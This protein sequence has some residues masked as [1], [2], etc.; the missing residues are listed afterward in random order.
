MGASACTFIRLLCPAL[1][2]APSQ[3]WLLLEK[4]GFSNHPSQP[5]LLSREAS[6]SR[7]VDRVLESPRTFAQLLTPISGVEEA[8]TLPNWV[9]G[10]FLGIPK[11]T[12]LVFP[13][14]KPEPG[15]ETRAPEKVTQTQP[16]VVCPQSTNI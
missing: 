6:E 3:D 4:P 11:G 7:E 15:I 10:A 1:R 16:S 14:Q 8:G 2:L 13:S 5:S 9:A 12:A